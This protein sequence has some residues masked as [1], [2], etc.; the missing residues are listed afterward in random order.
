MIF[1]DLKFS[2]TGAIGSDNI[3][4]EIFP[5]CRKSIKVAPDLRPSPKLSALQTA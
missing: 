2:G 5:H 4:A 3:I 1:P